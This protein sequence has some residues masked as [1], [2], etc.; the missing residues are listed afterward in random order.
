MTSYSNIV[1]AHTLTEMKNEAPT[2]SY[3]MCLLGDNYPS[4][5]NLRFYDFDWT[6]TATPDNDSVVATNVSGYSV[7]GRWL[8]VDFD[9]VPQVN[10][11]WTASSGPSAILNKPTLQ[12]VAVTGAYSDLSGKP[13]LA[14][15]ATSGSYNDLSNKPTIPSAYTFTFG[16]PTTRTVALSTA[17][18]ATNTA[19]AAEVT[20][21]LTSTAAL[22]LAGGTT[23]EADILIGST[24][25]VASGTGTVIGKFKNSL[26]GALVVGLA[27]NNA[28][29]SSYKLSLPA[30]WYFAVRQTNG[31]G[32]TVV[33]AYD[34]TAG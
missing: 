1:T 15:V 27:V 2:G 32:I 25:A 20:I 16:T 14:T 4:D 33:S 11:D 29:T 19:K 22:S 12:S 23:D 30:G 28:Q 21:T 31:T 17:Y 6:S 10:A 34:Q 8:K 18:Q 3:I 13:T 26:T 9:A 24:S 5:E 7:M